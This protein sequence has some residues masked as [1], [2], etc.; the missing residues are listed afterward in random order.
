MVRIGRLSARFLAAALLIVLATREHSCQ[1]SDGVDYADFPSNPGYLRSG[2]PRLGSLTIFDADTFDIFRS[3]ETPVAWVV[4]SHRM[5]LGPMGRIWIGYA[6]D[7]MSHRSRRSGVQILSLEGDLEHDIDLGCASP[8]GGIAFANGLAFVGCTASGFTG[9]V[10]VVDLE[11][12]EIVKV[13]DQVHPPE[14]DP[15][16]FGFFITT[17]DTVGDHILVV[18][19]GDPPRDYVRVTNHSAPYTGMGVINPYTLEFSGWLSDLES[20][21]RV[22]YVRDKTAK[23]GCSMS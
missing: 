4:F 2:T 15:L 3:V 22:F 5:E 9:V 21:L 20:G 14:K 18:G 6:Q 16:E 13:F 10:Y 8:D 12:L 11:S 17:L 7:G 1:N 23:R 19:F